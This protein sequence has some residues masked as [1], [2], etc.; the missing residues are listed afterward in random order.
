MILK[1]CSKCSE[2]KEL[3]LFYKNK[4]YRETVTRDK[5]YG[6]ELKYKYGS[7][8]DQYNELFQ[9]QRGHCAI[10]GIHQCLLTK[11]LYLDHSH[12]TKKVRGLLCHACNI[13]I[14]AFSDCYDITL[15]AAAYLKKYV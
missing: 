12:S 14:G 11:R 3:S 9:S 6:Y 10:C 13:G 1:K 2:E 15:K 7:S 8:T 4:K 5:K